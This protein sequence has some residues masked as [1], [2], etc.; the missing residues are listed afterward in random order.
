MNVA[1]LWLQNKKKR[2]LEDSWVKSHLIAWKGT[3][4]AKTLVL[5]HLLAPSDELDGLRGCFRAKM[6]YGLDS[7]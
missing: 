6:T 1:P 5:K 3:A 2:M 7:D 4:L